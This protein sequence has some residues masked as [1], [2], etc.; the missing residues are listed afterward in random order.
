M[1]KRFIPLF[2][3]LFFSCNSNAAGAHGEIEFLLSF[4]AGSDCV[5]LRNGKEYKGQ[6]AAEHLA[7]KYN[8]VKSRIKTPEDFITKIAS[9]SSMSKRPYKVR[10][11]GKELLTEKWLNEALISHRERGMD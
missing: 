5:F 11:E 6:Q 7:K 10:C 8:Y 1:K 9:R 2:F 3:L 4:V